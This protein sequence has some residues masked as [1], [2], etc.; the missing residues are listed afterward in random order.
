MNEAEI[1]TLG[2]DLLGKA[3]QPALAAL[4]LAY[5][6]QAYAQSHNAADS[7]GEAL[8]ALGRPAEAQRQFERALAL[9]Q[10][11]GAREQAMAGYRQHLLSAQQALTQP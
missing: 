6:S 2:F 11:G 10:A 5:N 3:K 9:G 1:N 4:V 8:L 7:H